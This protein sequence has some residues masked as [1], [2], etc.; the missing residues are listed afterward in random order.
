MRCAALRVFRALVLLA[1]AASVILL[2]APIVKAGFLVLAAVAV[3][4][5]AIHSGSAHAFDAFNLSTQGAVASGYA[6]SMVTSAPF[7]H[8]LLLDA[9]DDAAAFIAAFSA[10][11]ASASSGASGSCWSR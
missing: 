4:F 10:A 8:K 2:P 6:T 3:Y 7:D 9:Q 1:T 5:A 11:A